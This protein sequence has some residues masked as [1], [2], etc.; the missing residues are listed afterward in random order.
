L[1]CN[2][3]DL[4][5][6]ILA[7]GM[8]VGDPLWRLPLWAA[9]KK[10]LKSRLADLNNAPEGGLG[11][12]ITAAL[13]LEAFVEPTVKWAHIDTWAWNGKSRPGRPEGGEGLCLRALYAM[14]RKRYG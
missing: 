14:I 5:A 8:A 7:A 2:D 4:S 9:Y 1:F 12:A 6:E 13:F 3:D 11:G 10:Q